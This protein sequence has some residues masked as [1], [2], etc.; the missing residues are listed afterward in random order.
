MSSDEA[1]LDDD[2]ITVQEKSTTHYLRHLVRLEKERMALDQ[3]ILDKVSEGA[4]TTK[5]IFDL[6]RGIVLLALA[7]AILVGLKMC[8]VL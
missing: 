6:L 7:W 4:A 2:A 8:G 3:R 1:G 5:F